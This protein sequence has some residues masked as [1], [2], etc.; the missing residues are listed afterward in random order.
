MTSTPTGRRTWTVAPEPVGSPDSVALLRDYF[1]EVAGRYWG[2]PAT[3]EEID[4][5]VTGEHHSDDLVPPD[6]L[7]LVARYGNE[8]TGCAG[9]RLLRPGTAELK[10][11][12]VRPGARRSGGGSALMAAAES[13]ARSLGATRIVLDTRRDLTESHA[14]YAAHGYAEIP[15]YNHGVFADHWFAKD[16]GTD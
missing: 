15:A 1:A 6:G 13:A 10:R 16:L 12:Y 3:E 11:V 5:G 7:F 14:L 9:L 4:D 2:R 8:P